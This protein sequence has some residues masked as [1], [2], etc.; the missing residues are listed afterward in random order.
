M[1]QIRTS[2]GASGAKPVLLLARCSSSFLALACWSRS[3][4]MKLN[5]SDCWKGASAASKSGYWTRPDCPGR[6]FA[7]D[8][9][10][11]LQEI[12]SPALLAS[13]NMIT[14][15]KETW[16]AGTSRASDLVKRLLAMKLSVS[17]DRGNT[18]LLLVGQGGQ[19]SNGALVAEARCWCYDG[20]QKQGSDYLAVVY[21]IC[22]AS[23]CSWKSVLHLIWLQFN[24]SRNCNIKRA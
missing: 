23:Q 16:W 8:I 7:L 21:S 20:R 2:K 5:W 15:E 24:Y 4:D 13:G 6:L 19:F 12:G 1:L 18:G 3:S 11:D 17:S 10:E 9:N 22:R 14:W